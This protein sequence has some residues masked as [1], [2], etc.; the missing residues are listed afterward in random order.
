MSG[1]ILSALS[2][3]CSSDSSPD[4]YSTLPYF[5]AMFEAACIII[6]DLP[7]PGSPEISVREPLTIPPPRTL[8]NSPIPVLILCFSPPV[9][10]SM[11][12][13]A[14]ACLPGAAADRRRLSLSSVSCTFISVIVFHSPQNGH[15]PD[16]LALSPPHSVHIYTVFAFLAISYLSNFLTVKR[17]SFTYL[18]LPLR[19]RLP[20]K[21][22]YL[23]FLHFVSPYRDSISPISSNEMN[24]SEL[25]EMIKYFASAFSIR[26]SKTSCAILLLL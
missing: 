3:I 7:I 24:P 9:S 20:R 22:L 23:I 16:H 25:Y 1:H 19:F 5:F 15:C 2:F 11:S 13:F 6:V 4:T 10:I 21:V 12:L 18:F 8:S 17:Y 26:S 14:F